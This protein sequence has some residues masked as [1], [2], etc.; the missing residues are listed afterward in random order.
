MMSQLPINIDMWLK[1]G[2]LRLTETA[3][4]SIDMI[5]KKTSTIV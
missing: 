2:K 4:S 1:Q 5:K 3:H